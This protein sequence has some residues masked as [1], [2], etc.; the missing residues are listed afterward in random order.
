VARRARDTNLWSAVSLALIKKRR[1]RMP[2]V[3]E[4]ISEGRASQES[5]FISAFTP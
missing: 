1:A 4:E 5:E 3:P 2:A